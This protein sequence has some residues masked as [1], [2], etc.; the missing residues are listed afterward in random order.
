MILVEM[1]FAEKYLRMQRLSTPSQYYKHHLPIYLLQETCELQVVLLKA[2]IDREGHVIVQ[3]VVIPLGLGLDENAVRAVS[4][5]KFSPALLNSKPIKI[6][7]DIEVSY[8][9][10]KNRRPF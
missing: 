3:D 5:W 10:E 7:T 4:K 1:T 9:I 6:L 2:I 8:S